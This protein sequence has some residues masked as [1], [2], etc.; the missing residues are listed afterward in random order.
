M[1]ADT[2]LSSTGSPLETY[3]DRFA[4]LATATG[5]AIRIAEQPLLTQLTVRADQDATALDGPL[6]GVGEVRTVDAVRLLG[7]GPD[8]WLVI[9]P[10]G[11]QDHLA[12]ELAGLPAVVDVSGQ[13]TVLSL[14]GERVRSV[15]ATGCAV[16]L[17][18]TALPPGR[19][20]QTNLARAQVIIV[21]HR[22]GYWLLARSSFARYA[23]DWLLDAALEYSEKPGK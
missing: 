8:E 14:T 15:L 1:T 5:G 3:V 13:R 19:C 9:G 17:H 7:L 12:G 2:A 11:A 10:P 22:D 21:R 23:A 20:V 16:D 6:P 4:G 18:P